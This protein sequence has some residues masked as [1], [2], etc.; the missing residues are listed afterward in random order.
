MSIPLKDKEIFEDIFFCEK[1]LACRYNDY[2]SDCTTPT[3]HGEFLNLLNEEHRI[4]G[5]V[6]EEIHKRGWHPILQAEQFA[7]DKM[8]EKY[9]AR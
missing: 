7:I 2:T 8:R 9:Q 3:V 5:E 6:F 1:M 4:L